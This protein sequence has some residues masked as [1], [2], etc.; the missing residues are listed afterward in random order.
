MAAG[1][2]MLAHAGC[3]WLLLAWSWRPALLLLLLD[4]WSP[5]PRTMLDV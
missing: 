1:L 2:L 4:A 3:C 5:G